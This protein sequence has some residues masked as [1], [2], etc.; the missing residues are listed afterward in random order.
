LQRFNSRTY[1]TSPGHGR[2]TLVYPK[3]SIVFRQSADADSVFF[4]HGGRVK[5]SVASRHGRTAVIGVVAAGEFF[6]EGCLA[7]QK[8]RVATAETMTECRLVRLKKSA[9][10]HLLEEQ[11]SFA[12]LF[13]RH[14]LSR[15]SRLE[16]DLIDQLLYPAEKRL[17]RTLLMLAELDHA[18]TPHAITTPISQRTLAEMVGTTRPRVS[19]FMTKFRRMG[20]ISGGRD[21]LH[22]HRSLLRQVIDQL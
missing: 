6:G 19:H 11:P 16:S 2:T 18:H 7:G 17:G 15:A 14:L 5:L 4:L 12:R 20:L 21:R 8:H 9:V 3:D 10:L 22:V 1:L 13:G